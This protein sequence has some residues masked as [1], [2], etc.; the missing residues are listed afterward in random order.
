MQVPK[1]KLVIL[2]YDHHSYYV[3]YRLCLSAQCYSILRCES[4][5]PK[6]VLATSSQSPSLTVLH[7]SCTTEQILRL[8]RISGECALN[9]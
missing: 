5:T 9:R 2:N 4:H 8:C 7:Y 6:H 1:C 3:F